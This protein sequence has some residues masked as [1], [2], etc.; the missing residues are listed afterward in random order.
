MDRGVQM[1][2]PAR[3]LTPIRARTSEGSRLGISP[4]QIFGHPFFK[5]KK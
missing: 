1:G 5:F 3:A 2:S 4:T